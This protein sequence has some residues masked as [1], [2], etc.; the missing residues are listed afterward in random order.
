MR[1]LRN[2]IIIKRLEAE[3][4]S[5]GGIILTEQAQEV[6]T[7]GVVVEVGNGILEGGERVPLEVKVGD[8]VLFPAFVGKEIDVEGESF[9]IMVDTEVLAVTQEANIK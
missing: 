3:T 6:P 2:N 8:V 7:E 1:P 9:L 5:A 4:K